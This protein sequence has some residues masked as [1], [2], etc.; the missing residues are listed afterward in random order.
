MREV[1]LKRLNTVRFQLYDVLEKS[2][3][4]NRKIG[5]C[6]ELVQQEGGSRGSTEN[7]QGSDTTLCDV[8][9]LVTCHYTFIQ[10]HRTARFWAEMT[11]Q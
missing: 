3:L 4:W 10:T 1:N 9:T 11:C 5:G 6:Q 8:I 2:K 7:V